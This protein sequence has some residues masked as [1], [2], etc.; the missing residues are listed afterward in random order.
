MFFL[1]GDL[2][3]EVYMEQP[4][5]FVAQGESSS[6]VCLLRRSLYGLKQSPRARFGKFSTTIQE[7]GM[8]PSGANH[9]VFY[10]HFAPG[11]CI[12]LVVSVDDIVIT[13]NDQDGMTDLKQHLFKHFQTKDLGR[14]KYF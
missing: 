14:L 6:L 1:H 10:R 9:S 13:D 8:T 7:F 12:Y 3:K 11:R 2:E 4:P 5:G